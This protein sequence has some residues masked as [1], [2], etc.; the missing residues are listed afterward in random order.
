MMELILEFFGELIMGSRKVR[1][2]VKTAFFCAVLLVL[3]AVLGW[4]VYQNWAH[5]S[6]LESTLFLSAILA[7]A[8]GVGFWYAWK[9]HRNNWDKY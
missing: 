3:G 8:M 5:G 7:A 2:W 1:P 6:S 4:G 9:C